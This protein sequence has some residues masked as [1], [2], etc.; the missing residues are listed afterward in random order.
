MTTYV[1]LARDNFNRPDESPLTASRWGQITGFEYLVIQSHICYAQNDPLIAYGGQ[2]Y[3]G[4]AFSNDQYAEVTVNNLTTILQV[5][6]RCDEAGTCYYLSI[7]GSSVGGGFANTWSIVR[8]DAVIQ[9]GPILLSGSTTAAL[10]D[11]FR[12]EIVGTSITAKKN[13]TILGSVDDSIIAGGLTGF[14]L[15]YALAQSE[16]SASLFTAGDIVT[17]SASEMEGSSVPS[18]VEIVNHALLLLGEKTITSLA[19]NTVRASIAN[20]IYALTRNA[21][22]RAHPWSCAISRATLSPLSTAPSFGWKQS[23]PLPTDPY[24]LRVLALNDDQECGEGGDT[25][26]VEGRNLLTNTGSA[27]IRYI[28]KITDVTQYDALLYQAL[29]FR[30]ASAMAFPITGK[31]ALSQQM[32]QL[33]SGILQEARTINGQEGTPDANNVNTLSWVR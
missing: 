8:Y 17:A 18:E 6:V 3:I 24:C 5:I 26:K 29:A 27:N 28:G 16:A 19:D 21:V 13:G 30:L 10:G 7:Q 1:E 15:E 31:P 23:F 2:R 20:S 22:L 33:Y 9:D 12:I 25:W 32:W 4:A 14:F 11:V